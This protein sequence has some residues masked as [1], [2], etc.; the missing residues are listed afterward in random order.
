M[1]AFSSP[2]GA[3]L[4]ALNQGIGFVPL[5]GVGEG[6]S[7]LQALFFESDFSPRASVA[8]RLAQDKDSETRAALIDALSDNAGPS[9][10]P[11]HRRSG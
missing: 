2:K 3:I 4:F 9:G 5:P 11:Q 6:F 7:A 8:I 1:R 10:L